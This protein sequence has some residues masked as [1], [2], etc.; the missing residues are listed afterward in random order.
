MVLQGLVIEEVS[1]ILVMNEE[2]KE[3]SP[4][5]PAADTALGMLDADLPPSFKY[6]MY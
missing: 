4:V 3:K 5:I 2:G 1:E 6:P